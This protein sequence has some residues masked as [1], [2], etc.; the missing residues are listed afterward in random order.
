MK[1]H[2][3]A[4][5]GTTFGVTG[6]VLLGVFVHPALWGLLPLGICI[7]FLLDKKSNKK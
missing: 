6:G 7:G 5:F 2:F 1:S 4:V 3:S